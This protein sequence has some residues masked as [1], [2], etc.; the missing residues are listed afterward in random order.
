MRTLETLRRTPQV[1]RLLTNSQQVCCVTLLAPRIPNPTRWE[2]ETLLTGIRRRSIIPWPSS[3][4]F[5]SF[6]FIFYSMCHSISNSPS[7]LHPASSP[8]RLTT[9]SYPEWSVEVTLEALHSVTGL[10]SWYMESVFLWR[11]RILTYHLILINK[12]IFEEKPWRGSYRTDCC[13]IGAA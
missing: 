1:I 12:K 8:S 9:N 5:L 10:A 11:E 2:S 4:D 7:V 6:R 3:T 13:S